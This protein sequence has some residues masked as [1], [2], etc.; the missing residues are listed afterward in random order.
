MDNILNKVITIESIDSKKTSTGNIRKTIVDQDKVKFI[1]YTK[2]ADGT[3][4]K[5]AQQVSDMGLD[6]GSTVKV[7]YKEEAK[8]FEGEKGTVNYTERSV[9]SFQETGD[10]PVTTT[11][12]RV[13]PQAQGRATAPNFDAQRAS[14]ERQVAFKAAIEVFLAM[15]DFYKPTDIRKLTDD[16]TD[17][18]AGKVTPSAAP[19][20]QRDDDLPTVQIDDE[21]APEDIPFM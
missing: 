14:I 10:E 5:A 7:G 8:S 9:I 6:V 2:K 20:A 16:F 17:I 15:K 18:I 3:T 11:S 13:P 21:V 4:S 1:F 19:K 12:N